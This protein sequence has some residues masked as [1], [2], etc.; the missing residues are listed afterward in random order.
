M[1]NK[2]VFFYDYPIGSLGIAEED[3]NICRI[4]MNDGNKLIDFNIG[5]TTVIQEA[6]KQL[7]MYFNGTRSTFDLPLVIQGTSF[8]VAVWEA[9]RNIPIGEVR[10]YKEVA[11]MMDRPFAARAV[12]RANHDNPLLIVIPC[13]R[14]VGTKGNMVGYVGGLPAKQY[15]LNLEKL[16]V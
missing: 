14:V 1:N 7:T 12:G 9:L 5:E 11:S 10:S 13:H 15:L 2:H 16:Y 8:Q 4:F 6:A 3:G